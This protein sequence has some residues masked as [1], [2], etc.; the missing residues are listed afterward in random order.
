[1]ALVLHKMPRIRYR[2]MARIRRPTLFL[3][4]PIFG[5]PHRVLGIHAIY[6][7]MTSGG[8]MICLR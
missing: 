7:R 6:C 5:R 4:L 8:R 3:L 1:M 2:Q